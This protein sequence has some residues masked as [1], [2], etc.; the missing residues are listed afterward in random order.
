MVIAGGEHP[1]A[2]A[3]SRMLIVKTWTMK[4]NFST[5]MMCL[6]VTLSSLPVWLV[7]SAGM[8][9]RNSSPV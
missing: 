4:S 8:F 3:T 5:W 1:K 6:K 7:H 9:C 2:Q